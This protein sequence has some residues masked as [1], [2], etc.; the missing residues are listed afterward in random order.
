MIDS[1]SAYVSHD[2]LFPKRYK[3]IRMWLLNKLESVIGI[4]VTRVDIL[5]F[6]GPRDPGGARLHVEPVA[7]GVS[8]ANGIVLSRDGRTVAVA[9][10]AKHKVLLYDRDPVTD[11]LAYRE[12][13][14]VP[15]AVDNLSRTPAA[16]LKP[17]RADDGTDAFIAAG[18]PHKLSV[19]KVIG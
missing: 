1:H 6:S 2:H 13:V 4:P 19:L 15:F 17:D 3:G 18:H 9:S 11:Q 16:W 14:S 10:T 7:R 12:S 8:F 5:R